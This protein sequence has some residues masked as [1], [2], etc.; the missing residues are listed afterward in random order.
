MTTDAD[1]MILG[2]DFTE[3]VASYLKGIDNLSRLRKNEHTEPFH[4]PCPP[5]RP[6]C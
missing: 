4:S 6:P 2:N 1:D 5:P 3:R